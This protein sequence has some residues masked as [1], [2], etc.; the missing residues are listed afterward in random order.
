MGARGALASTGALHVGGGGVHP[1]R[2]SEG[3]HTPP[4]PDISL[5]GPGKRGRYRLYLS[6]GR[7]P[8]VEKESVQNVRVQ[9]SNHRLMVSGDY[10]SKPQRDQDSKELFKLPE[11]RT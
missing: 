9:T 5:E 7:G 4:V 10:R 11:S 1:C 8:D 2:N 6:Q 3:T